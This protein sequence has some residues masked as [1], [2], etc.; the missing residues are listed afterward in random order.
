[1]YVTH[2]PAS[3]LVTRWYIRIDNHAHLLRLQ[4]SN[5]Y[6][7]GPVS[8]RSS[9]SYGF[10][11]LRNAHMAGRCAAHGCQILMLGRTEWASVYQ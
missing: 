11:G 3:K 4:T 7:S 5:L 2:K 9:R 8:H 1:M 6:T 10:I